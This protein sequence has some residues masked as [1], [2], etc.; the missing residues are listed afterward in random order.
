MEFT[1]KDIIQMEVAP[2]LGCTE[3]AAVAL[4]AAA[5]ASLID[6]DDYDKI[7]VWVDPNIYKNGVA[8]SIPGAGDFTGID[9]AAALGAFGGDPSLKLEVLEPISGDT[10]STA[11]QY[12]ADKKLAVNLVTDK[13]GIYV[14]TQ[15]HSK[16]RKA[17]AV[18]QSMHDNIATLKLNDEVLKDHP[19]LCKVEKDKKDI[20]SLERWLMQLSLEEL[21]DLLKELDKEDLEFIKEG[22]EFNVKLAEHGLTTGPGLGVGSTLNRLCREGLLKK[23]IMLA[24]RIVTSAAADAR[25]SG[26][27]LP[28]MSSAGSGNH[29]L[30]AVL[31]IWA[32]KDYIV[33]NDEEEVLKA[34]A[35]SHVITGYVKA[36]TGRLTAVCGCSIAAGAGATAGITYL[37]G[38]HIKHIAWAIKNLISD[39]AGVI[40]DGAKAGCAFKLATAAGAAVQSSLFSLRGLCVKDTDGIVGITP[41]QTMKN[42]GE[43]SSQGMVETDRTI[44]DIMIRKQFPEE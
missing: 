21:V 9:L 33:H 32:V 29:G 38:G 20:L 2:A 3:P 13:G 22:V 34:I 35:L 15:I 42:V 23:D 8:V 36:H 14:R 6:G 44:L 28:A 1:I 19:M 37:M 24:A 18:I 30:T 26:V 5:A 10:L 39:L 4:S 25:M 43:L 12:I 7:D 17:E 41:E 27:K 31:P 11:R 16:D 40:C